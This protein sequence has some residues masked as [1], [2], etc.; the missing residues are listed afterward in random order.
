MS[1]NHEKLLILQRQLVIAV[2]F[3]LILSLVFVIGLYFADILRILCISLLLS[4]LMISIVDWLEKRLHNRVFAVSLVYLVMLG[5]AT[6]AALLL[7]PALTWQVSQLVQTT[8][9]ALPELLNKFTEALAPLEHRFRAYQIEVKSID[10]LNNII[11]T[12]PKPDPTAIVSRVTDVAMSTMTWLVY[13]ISI[14][15]I[16][17]YFLL[18]GEKLKESI[19]KIFSPKQH[20]FLHALTADIDKSLQSFLRGQIILGIAFGCLML[21]VYTCLGVQY[22]LLLSIFLSL[23]EILPVIGPPIGLIPA[24]ISVAFHGMTIPGNRLGHV[25]ILTIVFTILQQFKDNVVAPKYIGRVIGLH[26]VLVF[27]AIMIGARLDG[28]LGIILAVPAACVINVIFSHLH[29]SWSDSLE[30]LVMPEPVV[31]PETAPITSTLDITEPA[32]T[33]SKQG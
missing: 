12:M 2:L 25:I 6:V 18:D 31:M 16:T 27:I 15:V 20:A 33:E 11:G 23:M 24:I 1:N 9:N 29:F 19:I 28:V 30:P 8:I 14:S 4:Y 7:L 13:G 32:E 17:F 10:I 22:A 3:L 21:I 5:V 26:P